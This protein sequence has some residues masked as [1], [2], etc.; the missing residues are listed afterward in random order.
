MLAR[1]MP[2]GVLEERLRLWVRA[3]L[4]KGITPRRRA[5]RLA[6]QITR[7]PEWV[8]MYKKGKLDADFDTTVAILQFFNVALDDLMKD[9]LPDEWD[10]Q[11]W[12]SVRPLGQA[13]KQWLLS[14]IRRIAE[15]ENLVVGTPPIQQP[16]P[17]QSRQGRT[18]RGTR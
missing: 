17:G 18:V 9:R 6:D 4:E 10:V 14:V 11:I 15:G 8:S 13:Q 3:R 2:G 5:T 12:E 16:A 7:P 1:R